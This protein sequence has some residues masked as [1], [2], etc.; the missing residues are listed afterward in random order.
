MLQYVTREK[1]DIHPASAIF[2]ELPRPGYHTPAG[3][4]RTATKF[5]C[6]MRPDGNRRMKNEAN[7]AFTATAAVMRAGYS[8]DT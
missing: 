2:L 3:T 4:T 1:L 7:H 8:G 5:H 6:G